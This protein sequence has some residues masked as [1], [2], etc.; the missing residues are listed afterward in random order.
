MDQVVNTIK[1]KLSTD[2]LV[3]MMKDGKNNNNCISYRKYK[4]LAALLGFNSYL[5]ELVN[6]RIK[7]IYPGYKVPPYV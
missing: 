1:N 7:S 6:F 2:N 4:E 3:E 5:T